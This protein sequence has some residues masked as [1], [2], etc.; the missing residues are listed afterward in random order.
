LPK[1]PLPEAEP[2]DESARQVALGKEALA[3]Q[4]Y[5]RAVS[6]F[7]QSTKLFAHDAMAHFLL[8]QALFALGKYDEAVDAIHAGM[9]LRPDWPKSRFR[10]V[11]LYGPNAADFPEHLKRLEAVLDRHP[12]DPLLLF[13]LAYELWFDGRQNEA[14]PMFR[15]AAAVAP[16]KTYIER[17]LDADPGL[18]VAAR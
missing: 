4:E 7:R 10:S 15:R 16:D 18:P 11:E 3:A 17:F 13:L 5:G 14:L 2:K 1:A 8:A 12:D 6:R 9:R